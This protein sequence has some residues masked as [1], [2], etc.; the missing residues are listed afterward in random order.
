[1]EEFRLAHHKMVKEN[2]KYLI[3]ILL[4]PLDVDALSNRDLQMYIRTRTYIDATRLPENR[5]RYPVHHYS[6]FLSKCL[7]VC[8]PKSICWYIVLLSQ[9]L[10]GL[11]SE[12]TYGDAHRK[13][14]KV[15]SLV[16]G[17]IP[18]YVS[19]RIGKIFKFTSEFRIKSCGMDSPG[20][21]IWWK[22]LKFYFACTVQ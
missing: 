12:K 4:E 1:M 2:K 10:I 14:G 22:F 21:A 17:S 13:T 8:R 5:H 6:S 9:P 15:S 3:V 7:H 19:P 20:S 11:S 16:N 18:W